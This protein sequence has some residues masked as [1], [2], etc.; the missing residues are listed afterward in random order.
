MTGGLGDLFDYLREFIGM[1]KRIS[2]LLY[3]NTTTI[4]DFRL[5]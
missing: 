3:G 2:T 5:F 4:S 1:I